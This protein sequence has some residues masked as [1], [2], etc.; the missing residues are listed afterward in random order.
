MKAD[1]A[2][3]RAAGPLDNR[4]QCPERIAGSSQQIVDAQVD[5]RAFL[6]PLR[7]YLMPKQCRR[8]WKIPG[9]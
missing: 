4:P 8:T 9:Q 3:H 6:Q 1:M 2:D 5:E 7:R